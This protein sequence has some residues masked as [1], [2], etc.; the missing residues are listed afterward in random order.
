MCYRGEKYAFGHTYVRPHET[1]HE[2]TRKFFPNEVWDI[3][4]FLFIEA[5]TIYLHEFL[6]KRIFH[7]IVTIGKIFIIVI[8][9]DW[10]IITTVLWDQVVLISDQ[11]VCLFID[12]L[13]H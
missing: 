8:K 11:N 9:P 2:P 3:I 6:C 1:F 12:L 10:P 5:R 4:Y 13:T 7:I